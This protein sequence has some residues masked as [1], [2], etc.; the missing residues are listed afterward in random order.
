MKIFKAASVLLMLLQFNITANAFDCKI[1][2]EDARS[3][4]DC[5]FIT[6]VNES[7]D[8]YYIFDSYFQTESPCL[9]RYDKLNSRFNYNLTPIQQYL[10][11]SIANDLICFNEFR[12]IIKSQYTY[13]F[14]VLASGKT[15]EIA[16]STRSLRYG[17]Y[18]DEIVNDNNEPFFSLHPLVGRKPDRVWVCIAVYKDIFWLDY[19]KKNGVNYYDTCIENANNFNTLMIPITVSGVNFDERVTFPGVTS[20]RKVREK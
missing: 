1:A 10:S 14:T 7:A 16:L 13:N 8:D 5:I 11:I 17:Y 20:F 4:K 18:F 3:T 12:P 6:L 2:V 19:L 9:F 15:I